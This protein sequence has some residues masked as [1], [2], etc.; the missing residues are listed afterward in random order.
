MSQIR[1]IAVHLLNDFSGS[2]RV[3]ADFCAIKSIQSQQLTIVTNSSNGFLG[4]Q[5]GALE[6]IWYPRSDSRVLNV[7]ALL[8]AQAQIFFIVLFLCRKNRR[9]GVQTVVINNTILC[10]ASMLASR[11][12]GALTIVYIQELLTTQRLLKGIAE[13]VIRQTVDEVLIVSSIISEH[14]KLD[15]CRVTLIPNGLRSDFTISREL[16]FD[17]KFYLGATLFVGSLKVHK[18]VDELLKIAGKLPEYPFQ[19]VLNCSLAELEEFSNKKTIPTNL[20]VFARSDELENKYQEAFLL[21]NLSLSPKCTEAFGLTV[22]EGLSAG[23]PCIVPP[24]G[25]HMDYFSSAAGYAVDA[26]DTIAIVNFIK[27]LRSDKSRW[28]SFSMQG[29]KIAE[30]YSAKLF[31]H[32]ADGFVK[33]IIRRNFQIDF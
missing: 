19:A 12:M 10:L 20:T 24:S 14:Y 5:L 21:M 4:P 33:A 28:L 11:L 31:R 30:R 1:F 9:D 15:D 8:L 23:C 16:D 2:P 29:L 18:G 6:I 26:R 25:G 22:L 27:V 13:W 7:F 32:R 3:L 17:A